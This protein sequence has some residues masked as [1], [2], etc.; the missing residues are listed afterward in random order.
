M[1]QTITAKH[2]IFVN[3]SN[4]Q[5]LCDAMKA[6]SNACNCVSE[7]IYRTHYLSRYSVQGHIYYA[8]SD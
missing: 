5:V 7:Y 1:Q 3:T 4:K 8:Y 2:Q 6:Y